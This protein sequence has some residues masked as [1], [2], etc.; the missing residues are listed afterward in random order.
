MKCQSC[1]READRL[2]RVASGHYLCDACLNQKGVGS[3]YARG[4]PVGW[5]D[6]L[7][8]AMH[9]I[10]GVILF[11]ALA[12]IDSPNGL[13]LVLVLQ[14]WYITYLLQKQHKKRGNDEH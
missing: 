12:A 10:G 11:G 3:A 5:A 7:G 1:S 4:K 9:I 6:S 2:T 13:L 14:G 8:T